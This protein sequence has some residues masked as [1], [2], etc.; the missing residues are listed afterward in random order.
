MRS[1]LAG[2]YL[3]KV[4]NRNIKT[5]CEISSKLRIKT[6]ERRHVVVVNF[7]YISH[8]VLILDLFSNP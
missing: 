4:S 3:L 8:L 2:V 6:P 7:E 1:V 5:K